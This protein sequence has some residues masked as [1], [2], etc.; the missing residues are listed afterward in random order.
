[1]THKHDITQVKQ[2]SD[3]ITVVERHVTL[4]K[5]GSEYY[6]ICPFHDDHE[7][8]LQVNE[9]KQIFKCFAC[10][11]GGDAIDFLQKLGHSFKEALDEVSGNKLTSSG[12]IQ[13]D[14]V[15]ARPKAIT[16]KQVTPAPSINPA[17]ISHYKHGKPSRAWAYLSPEGQTLGYICRFDIGDGKKEVL[18]Y[19]YATDGTR[20][21][22]RWQ[23]FDKPRPLYNLDQLAKRPDA[24]VMVVEG[25]K[26]ADAAAVLFPHVVVTT[27]QGGA[28]AI[29]AADWTPLSGRTVVLWP[30]NDNPG[31]QAMWDIA[32]ILAPTAK[33]LKWIPNPAEAPKHWDL[34]D[35]DDWT[36]EQAQ[37]YARTAMTAVPERQAPESDPEP[38][39]TPEPEQT[40]TPEAPPSDIVDDGPGEWVP[41]S[42]MP[43]DFEEPTEGPDTFR[44]LGFTP[45][46]DNLKHNFFSNASQ[47]ILSL[48]PSSMSINNL[49][50]LAPLQYWE[51][52]FQGAKGLSTTAAVNWLV[53]TSMAKGVF[54]DDHIRGRGAWCDGRE[55]V[56]HAGDRLIINGQPVS[57]RAQSGKYVYEAGRRLPLSVENPLST[58]EA[59][60]LMDIARLMNW[61]R[62]IS[63]YLLVGWCII[64]PF[65]GALKWRPHIWLTGAAGTGKSWVFRN[66]VRKLM[67]GIAMPVQGETSE[68]GI[69]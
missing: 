50:Q 12:N 14:A 17:T 6:G 49:M 41:P 11:A 44:F 2:N 69:R 53:N 60:K 38:K 54:S 40:Q 3:I 56:I 22:W 8:S 9:R 13:R 28:K 52:N 61:E 1:M 58:A 37:A 59:N 21:E 66:I 31:L 65:C 18:P 5:R 63:A 20:S 55:T 51:M 34:A 19:T 30:D 26:T 35:A 57:L 4:K 10:G 7:T 27:W 16:W 36:P 25:E 24:T 46:G 64:A 39:A 45:E 15:K 67:E 42:D 32:D 68:A 62:E 48:N 29:A 23:G 33:L 43:P 47:T